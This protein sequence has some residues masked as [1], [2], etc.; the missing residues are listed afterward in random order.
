MEDITLFEAMDAIDD[1]ID[2]AYYEDTVIKNN[3]NIPASNKYKEIGARDKAYQHRVSTNDRHAA[4]RRKEADARFNQRISHGD[5]VRS[6]ARRWRDEDI[7]DVSSTMTTATVDRI[8]KGCTQEINRL[9]DKARKLRGKAQTNSKAAAKLEEVERLLA[10]CKADLKDCIKIKKSWN[11][12][13][14]A[15][16]AKAAKAIDKYDRII[17]ARTLRGL[18]VAG[19]ILGGAVAAGG[20]AYGGYKGVNAIRNKLSERKADKAAT[21]A[22]FDDLDYMIDKVYDAYIEGVIDDDEFDTYMDYLDLDNYDYY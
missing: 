10:E 22:A 15:E 3:M 6:T 16:K 13:S 5:T 18:K 11:R 17:R 20:A 2:D 1:L 8:I 9:E 12:M 7:E 21:E 4:V 14:N 19:I